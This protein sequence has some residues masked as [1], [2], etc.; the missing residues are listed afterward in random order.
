MY[1]AGIFP[2]EIAV[3]IIVYNA[4]RALNST[5][6]YKCKKMSRKVYRNI[7]N[8]D[9]D[10]I[11]SDACYRSY[12][13][14]PDFINP[15]E[16]LDSIIEHDGLYPCK[17]CKLECLDGNFMD[18]IQCEICEN[19]FHAECANLQQD[20]SCYVKGSHGFICSS[21][22]NMSVLPFYNADLEFPC[23]KCGQN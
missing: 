18:S 5:Y 13:P 15:I 7:Q 6:H 12:L 23:K 10:Y 19:W 2:A 21:R 14:F 22:C 20:F 4:K 1:P 11:C 3:I 16:F 8:N 9:L 17:K